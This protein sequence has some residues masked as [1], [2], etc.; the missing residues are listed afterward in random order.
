M[1]GWCATGTPGLHEK[2]GERVAAA[3]RAQHA[4]DW[5]IDVGTAGTPGMHQGG[6]GGWGGELGSEGAVPVLPLRCPCGAP[7]EHEGSFECYFHPPASKACAD[8]ATAAFLD[9]TK[10]RKVTLYTRQRLVKIHNIGSLLNSSERFLVVSP[11]LFS[12]RRHADLTP[13]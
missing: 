13:Q 10:H 4:R 6:G 11:R 2:V 7:E 9:R 8:V 3:P 12:I 5:V 1:V